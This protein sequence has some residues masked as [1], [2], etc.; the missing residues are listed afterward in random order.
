MFSPPLPGNYYGRPGHEQIIRAVGVQ[1]ITWTKS[2]SEDNTETVVAFLG[3]S[4]VDFNDYQMV[5]QEWDGTC[6]FYPGGS[7]TMWPYPEDG[8]CVYY[9]VENV[10]P[11]DIP[12]CEEHV[13]WSADD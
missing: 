13:N 11:A 5:V 2:E 3:E 10:D 1:K 9:V 7:V 6:W 12:C 8:T 4:L